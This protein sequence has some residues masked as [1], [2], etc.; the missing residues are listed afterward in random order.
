M[1]KR[2]LVSFAIAA[3]AFAFGAALGPARATVNSTAPA[4]SQT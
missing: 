2:L 4:V 1:L 3:F